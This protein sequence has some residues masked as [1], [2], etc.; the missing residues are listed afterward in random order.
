MILFIPQIGSDMQSTV[1]LHCT[2]E[3]G[4]YNP[5]NI[6]DN[7]SWDPAKQTIYDAE[8]AYLKDPAGIQTW[9]GN[10][11]AFQARGGKICKTLR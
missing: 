6:S 5:N 1:R 3:L 9:K 2:R 7:A 11:T 4:G 10:L 8:Y